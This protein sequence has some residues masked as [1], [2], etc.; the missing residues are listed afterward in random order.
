MIA[1]QRPGTGL[2]PGML[3]RVVGRR[4][5]TDIPAGTLLSLEMLA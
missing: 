5:V 2:A 3:E 4:A 1:L